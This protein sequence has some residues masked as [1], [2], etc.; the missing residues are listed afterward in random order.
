MCMI[1]SKYTLQADGEN[2][3]KL[4]SSSGTVLGMLTLL[5][6]IFTEIYYGRYWSS[7]CSKNLL[8]EHR[9]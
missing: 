8:K 7:D 3:L 5:F 9:Q 6:H 1:E 2:I 4:H